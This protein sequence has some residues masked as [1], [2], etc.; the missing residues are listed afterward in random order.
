MQASFVHG[1]SRMR[2]AFVLITAAAASTLALP[3]AAG[4]SPG[5]P[6]VPRW[7][8]PPARLDAG[9][10]RVASHEP[11]G[12]FMRVDDH[13]GGSRAIVGTWRFTWTSDGTAYPVP[14]PL[15]AVVDFGTQQWHSDGTELIVSGGRAPS[16]GDTCMGSW[17][18]TGPST[19]RFKHIGMSWAS[20]D[21]TPA[22]TPAA[23]IGPAI[24]RATVTLNRAHNAFEGT[25][26]LDQYAR[27]EVTL[28]EHVGGRITAVRFT[29]D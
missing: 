6:E 3:A 19:Y 13:D 26:S 1:R 11:L 27:D 4:C 5:V 23:Y 10:M 18:Q 22:A 2:S 15:G 17:E 21:S 8:A 25:F 9:F 29:V 14:I 16:T 28:L 20:S 7:D 24:I 12:G